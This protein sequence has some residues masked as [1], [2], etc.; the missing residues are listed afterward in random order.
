MT[1]TN[2][3][4]HEGLDGWLFLTGGSNFVT[5]LYQRDGGHLPDGALRRWRDAILE[6]S[7]RCGEL[8][9]RYAHLIVPEKLTIYGHKQAAALVD[10]ELAPSIRLRDMLADAA[11][12]SFMVDLV[13]PM[14]AVRDEIDLYWR[15]DTHWTPQG[16]LLGYR[17]LCEALSLRPFDE[18]LARTFREYAAVMD[19][20]GKL[21]PVG[22]ETIR[23]YEWTSNATRVHANGVARILETP[24]FGGE[25]H[26]GSHVKFVNRTAPNGQKLLLF[27]DSFSSQRGNLLTGLLAETL[28]EVDFIWSA[29][30]DWAHV[31]ET[32][33]DLVVT[34][35]AERYMALPPNDNFN[36]RLTEWRQI[37]RAKTKRLRRWWREREAKGK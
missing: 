17:R 4:V 6:R 28:R 31:R 2:L 23:E 29:N 27:G 35:I 24:E 1:E 7:R 36:L 30:I 3:I 11:G 34:Q 33:P 14:R 25:I 9:I 5:T 10:P 19:L 16:C 26:V 37:A 22:W 15:T 32:R 20:G 12:A 13:A 8:G 21:D 18:P